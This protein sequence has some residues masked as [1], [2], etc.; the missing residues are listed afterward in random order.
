LIE[1]NGKVSMASAAATIVHADEPM[2]LHIAAPNCTVT[3]N[4]QP[5]KDG[6]FT[7]KKGDNFLFM[8]VNSYFGH[9]T[10][11]TAIRFI[12]SGGYTLKNPLDANAS[13]PWCWVPFEDAKYVNSDYEFNLLPASEQQAIQQRIR[14]IID[15][16]LKSVT[17]IAS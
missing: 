4:G 10:K 13:S 14:N 2:E 8:A 17:D 11:D 1:A 3:V 16:H 9:W 5:G 7:L 6:A 15:E 12:E